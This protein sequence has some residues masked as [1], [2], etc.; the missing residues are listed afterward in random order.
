MIWTRADKVAACIACSC[1]VILTVTMRGIVSY[2]DRDVHTTSLSRQGQL[3]AR[4]RFFSRTFII[5]VRIHVT[6]NKN[7]TADVLN[8]RALQ[9]GKGKGHPVTR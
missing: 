8:Y 4:M 3:F 1:P 2:R 9:W 6:V 7:L 5:R